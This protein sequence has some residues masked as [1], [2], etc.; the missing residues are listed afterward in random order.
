MALLEEIDNVETARLRLRFWERR[1]GE[2]A[3]SDRVFG[4]IG[5]EGAHEEHA[6]EIAG[7]VGNVD[8]DAR[9]AG[10]EDFRDGILVENSVGGHNEDIGERRHDGGHGFGFEVEHG[11]D[12]GDFV[13]VKTLVRRFSEGH[14]Q[15]DE[16]FE[17]GFFV[18]CSV[19]FAKE[20]VEEFGRGPGEGTH[21]VH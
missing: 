19:V 2:I 16:G 15:G 17:T 12:D 5:D 11:G 3:D 6:D 4:I 10:G 7:V 21:D 18:N 1:E 8:R 14:V 20:V 13:F 9:V